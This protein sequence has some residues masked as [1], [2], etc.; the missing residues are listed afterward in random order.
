MYRKGTPSRQSWKRKAGE[1][2][3][4]SRSNPSC[5]PAL[6]WRDELNSAIAGYLSSSSSSSPF[7]TILH[8]AA[9][10]PRP[11]Q[12]AHYS[13]HFL[14]EACVVVSFELALELYKSRLTGSLLQQCRKVIIFLP[15]YISTLT[16]PVLSTKLPCSS[17]SALLQHQ[18]RLHG[19]RISSGPWSNVQRRI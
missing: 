12:R 13:S 14:L 2:E 18:Q 1:E 11:P 4:D 3:R 8:T 10:D 7:P 16:T 17:S 5:S 19:S 15:H 6:T 9:S